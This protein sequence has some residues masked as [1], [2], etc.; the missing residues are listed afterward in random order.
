MKYILKQISGHKRLVLAAAVVLALAIIFYRNLSCEYELSGDVLCVPTECYG[1]VSGYAVTELDS[2]VYF[3]PTDSDPQMYLNTESLGQIGGL[4]L[5]I[6]GASD[7]NEEIKAQVFYAG[8]GEGFSERRSVTVKLAAQEE[9]LRIPLP[10]G[11]YAV[12]RL[13]IDGA[14]ELC[15]L[16]AC[17]EEMS[18]TLYISDET[19]NRC[20]WCFPAVLIG[21]PLIYWAHGQRAKRGDAIL[22]GVKPAAGR[23]LHW[24]Y[25]RILAAVLVIL[26]HACSPM[27]TELEETGGADWKRLV[28]VC[29]LTLG[30]TCNLLYVMLSGALLLTPKGPDES[31]ESTAAFYIR[32]VSRVVIPLA[33]YYLLLLSLNDEVGFLPPRNIGSA[34]KRIVSGAPDAAP[35]LWLIYTIA[36]LYLAT[37][38]FRVMAAHLSDRM[39]LSLAAV[40]FV[41]NALT[42]YLPIFGMTFG[43]STF[44]AGWEGV[45][46]LGFILTRQYEIF[47]WKK[48]ILPVGAAAF[49]A[50]VAVVFADSSQMNYVYGSTPP[51]MFMSCAIFALFLKYKDKFVSKRASRI[52][53]AWSLIVR[54]CAKYSYSIILIHWYVLFVVVEGRLH[55]TALRFGVFGG[56]AATVALTFLICLGMAIVFDNTVVIVCNAIFDKI[57]KIA[58]NKKAGAYNNI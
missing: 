17:T 26:A 50:A 27:V 4:E 36:A 46:L 2:G 20:L 30:L 40:I 23:K 33:A 51:M 15:G 9:R 16:Y 18:Q 28:M 31:V 29:G 24:D 57:V 43:A 8:A 14:F 25:M 49:A 1:G 35:H 56:I 6:S 10:L 34:L 13:D 42:N 53:A 22:F 48:Y 19:L 7:A 45:F 12:L 3:E 41:L 47:K 54:M 38:F 55:I 39:L 21:F 37:P 11:E 58:M 5:V 32:R 44:L 52:G